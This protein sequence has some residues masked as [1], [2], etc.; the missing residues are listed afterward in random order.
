MSQGLLQQ[1]GGVALSVA[2]A[3]KPKETQDVFLNA[4]GTGTQVG[5]LLPFS[6]KHELE[7]DRFGLIFSAMAGFDPRESIAL[8]ERMEKLSAS[9]KPPEFLSTH[10]SEGKRI[11]ELQKVMP[12]ALKY[13]QPSKN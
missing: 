1:L 2:I 3:N 7:A 11:D 8:W 12:E 6:R 5:V 10:P 4:Y 13:Y 9:N